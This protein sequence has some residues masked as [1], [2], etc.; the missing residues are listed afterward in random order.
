MT[1]NLHY[2]ST[3]LSQG[4]ASDEI[5]IQIQKLGKVLYL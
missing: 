5:S 2:A 4:Q 1:S 3:K